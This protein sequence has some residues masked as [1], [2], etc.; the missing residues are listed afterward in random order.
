VLKPSV[1]DLSVFF[2]LL[3]LNF[4]NLI[5]PNINGIKLINEPTSLDILSTYR[6]KIKIEGTTQK[7]IVSAIESNSIPNSDSRPRIL[8]IFP[9]NT[10]KIPAIKINPPAFMGSLFIIR[11]IDK[12]PKN[13]FIRVKILGMNFFGIK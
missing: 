5:V 6:E 13:M 9:S 4:A 3:I 8:A 2:G 12:K 11:A 7:D 10:S 1:Y